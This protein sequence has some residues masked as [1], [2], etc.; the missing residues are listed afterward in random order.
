MLTDEVATFGIPTMK[1]SSL[2]LAFALVA[3]TAA[4]ACAPERALS[5][6]TSGTAVASVVSPT[7][8][9]VPL[10]FVVD[11]VRLQRDRVPVLTNDQ[12]ASVQVVK[13]SAALRRYGPDASYGVVLITTKAAPRT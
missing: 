10:L 6:Q 9:Q 3:S 8:S 7:M 4:A 5:P 2:T 13:G 1:N 12:I 11:G